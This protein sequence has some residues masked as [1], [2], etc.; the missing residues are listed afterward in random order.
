MILERLQQLRPA[1]PL[2][3]RLLAAPPRRCFHSAPAPAAG[4]LP[5]TDR[6]FDDG[7]SAENYPKMGYTDR[8]GLVDRRSC[9]ASQPSQPPMCWRPPLPESVAATAVVVVAAVAAAVAATTPPWSGA[10]RRSSKFAND[11][12]YCRAD[13]NRAMLAQPGEANGLNASRQ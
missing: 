4:R 12:N 8:W 2:P 13:Q 6:Q 1:R 7:E 9:L 3:A 10:I 5:A 11:R